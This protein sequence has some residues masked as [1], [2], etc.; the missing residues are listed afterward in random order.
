MARGG[1]FDFQ[2][3]PVAALERGRA[4]IRTAAIIV[5][6][7]IAGTAITATPTH[8]QSQSGAAAR[9][10]SATW[11]TEKLVVPVYLKWIETT[12]DSL[13]KNFKSNAGTFNTSIRNPRIVS[14]TS[15]EIVCRFDIFSHIAAGKIPSV[16]IKNLDFRYWLPNGR[17]TWE[18][19]SYPTISI[20]DY[21]KEQ[22]SS[23]LDK[24][25]VGD[26]P[27]LQFAA[28]QSESAP[29]A[30]PR[31]AMEAL[32][33]QQSAYNS[34]VDAYLRSQGVDVDGIKQAEADDTRKYAESC[35]RSGGTWGRPVDK[36]GNAGRLGCYHPT[37][38]R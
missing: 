18:L 11:E 22:T 28:S 26:T 29:R 24:L 3:S 14:A 10:C 17:P 5:L 25:Y 7:S 31:N 32:G 12:N 20:A 16:T 6:G 38:E 37:G 19:L 4:F 21:T 8:A 36:Y 23:L 1:I 15:T 30:K 34:E 33:Q 27:W 9:L 2:I 35:R 13:L